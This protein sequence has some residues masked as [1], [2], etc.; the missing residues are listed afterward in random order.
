MK[1][2]PAEIGH[3]TQLTAL[4]V[5][6]NHLESLPEGKKKEEDTFLSGCV[7]VNGVLSS[8]STPSDSQLR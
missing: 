5:S 4:D 6:N 3:L 2:L 8:I 7:P 1:E